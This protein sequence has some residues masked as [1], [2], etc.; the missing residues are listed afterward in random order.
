MINSKKNYLAFSRF[1]IIVLL[2]DPNYS[3]LLTNN[4]Q[5]FNVFFHNNDT[6]FIGGKSHGS[7]H[8]SFFTLTNF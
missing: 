8:E 4:L 7:S 6:F 3:F 1:I 2:V 5:T